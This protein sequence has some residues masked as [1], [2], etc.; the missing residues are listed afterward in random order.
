MQSKNW[1]DTTRHAKGLFIFQIFPITECW[2]LAQQTVFTDCGTV[3]LDFLCLSSLLILCARLN[4]L[5]V[6]FWV[7]VKNTHRTVSLSRCHSFIQ[8][9][10]TLII[11]FAPDHITRS[12]SLRFQQIACVLIYCEKKHFVSLCRGRVSSMWEKLLSANSF[13]N[14]R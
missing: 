3:L 13:V 12:P 10:S 4:W 11:S 1:F 6:C 14:R 9:T 8:A 7:H 5:L 2:Y